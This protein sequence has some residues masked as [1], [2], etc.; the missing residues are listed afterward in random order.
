MNVGLVLG[1]GALFLVLI[2]IG[3]NHALATPSQVTITPVPGAGSSPDCTKTPEEGC[4]IPMVATV[5]VGGVVI[6]SNTDTGIHTFTSGLPTVG[7]DGVFDS[8]F[9]LPDSS[10]EWR[11]DTAGEYPYFCLVHPW[12][13]GTIVVT[14]THTDST[15]IIIIIIVVIIMGIIGTIMFVVANRTSSTTTTPKRPP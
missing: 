8:S 15:I 11:P 5:D 6:M 12:M 1:S 2:S 10:F 4:I 7:P 13:E 9:L 14:P 3:G